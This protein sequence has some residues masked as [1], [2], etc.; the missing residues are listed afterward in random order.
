MLLLLLLQVELPVDK[1]VVLLDIGFTGSDPNHGEGGR[2]AP[3]Q[4]GRQAGRH[5]APAVQ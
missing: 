1:G 4:A 2:Q 3:R 5:A